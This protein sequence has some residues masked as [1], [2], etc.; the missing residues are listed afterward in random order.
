[1]PFFIC[2]H[3]SFLLRISV[4]R[5]SVSRYSTTTTIA[6]TTT[7]FLFLSVSQ[8]LFW[9]WPACLVLSSKLSNLFVFRLSPSLSFMLAFQHCP[10]VVAYTIPYHKQRITKV[11][12]WEKRREKN[13]FV[14]Q[15]EKVIFMSQVFPIKSWERVV[16]FWSH[17]TK[18]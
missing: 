12:F 10:L 3:Y 16:M 14:L 15:E 6:A 11:A 2:L 5:S 7:N 13:F 8:S 17:W 4:A 1:M 9:N 18:V